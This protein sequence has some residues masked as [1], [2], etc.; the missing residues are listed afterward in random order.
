MTLAETTITPL[1]RLIP[2]KAK[3]IKVENTTLGANSTTT[4]ATLTGSGTVTNIWMTMSSQ[5]KDIRL[6][7]FVD[8]ETYPSINI[9]VASL[10]LSSF[11]GSA[12]N[13]INWNTQNIHGEGGAIT[14][15]GGF[16]KYPIPYNN[17]CV[18][19]AVTVA[20]VG[21]YC[22]VD[23]IP[24]LNL[25]YKLKSIN[26]SYTIDPITFATA[27]SSD[28][29]TTPS[30]SAGWLV[31]FGYEAA[32]TGGTGD[33]Y[34]ERNFNLYMDGEATASHQS[35]G[36][37][38]FFFGSFYWQYKSGGYGIDMNNSVSAVSYRNPSNATAVAVDLLELCNGIYFDSQCRLNLPTEGAVGIG[39]TCGYVALFYTP[40]SSLWSTS[41]SFFA[42]AS[43]PTNASASAGDTTANVYFVPPYNNGGSP[44][45]KYVATSTPSSIVASSSFSPVVVSGLSN[46]TAYT[47]TVHATNAIGSSLESAASNSVTPSAGGGSTYILDTFTGSDSTTS[48]GTGVHTP[49]T[50]VPAGAWSQTSEFGS[51]GSWGISSNKAYVSSAPGEQAWAVIDGGHTDGTLTCDITLSSTT[52]RTVRGLMFRYTNASSFMRLLI[53]KVSGTNQLQLQTNAATRALQDYSFTDGSTYTIK[54]IMNGTN[55]KVYVNNVLQIDNTD[56]GNTH[57]GTK[58]G[59]AVYANGSTNDDLAGRWDSLQFT[60]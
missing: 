35:S 25:P 41:G 29:F 56:A 52:N 7:V 33:T 28:L 18:I 8:G 12:T 3:R 30:G 4:L 54:I 36:T 57:T 42:T 59:L 39:H 45:L 40:S 50:N 53:V 55:I 49:D 27:D 43:A 15:Q 16:M 2:K 60:S 1:S 34:L 44:I 19:K 14:S 26:R 51:G 20:S 23:Y 9:D 21:F 48:I 13:G 6:Q 10:F 31:Y 32:P 22:M 11:I 24:N 47:F 38:D 5:D 58:I 37:E 46:G 17:G